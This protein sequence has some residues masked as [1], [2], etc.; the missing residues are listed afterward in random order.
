MNDYGLPDAFRQADLFFR[1]DSK[2]K[3]VVLKTSPP[4]SLLRKG[5]LG[6]SSL[7]VSLSR[8]GM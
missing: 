1:E 3:K 4:A 6:Y 7:K 2:R 5:E 8:R